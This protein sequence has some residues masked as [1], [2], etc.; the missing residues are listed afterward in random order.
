[1]PGK[2]LEAAPWRSL[3]SPEPAAHSRNTG[4]IVFQGDSPQVPVQYD[5]RL[6][7]NGKVP[8]VH[9][10]AWPCRWKNLDRAPMRH[11]SSCQRRY[12]G[13]LAKSKTTKPGQTER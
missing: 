1:M 5:V 2:A 9:A 3:I 11:G 4:N 13:F 6:I 12:P 7:L 8:L 10:S